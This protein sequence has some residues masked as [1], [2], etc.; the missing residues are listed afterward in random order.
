MSENIAIVCA[1]LSVIFVMAL[2]RESQRKIKPAT[3]QSRALATLAML[4]PLLLLNSCHYQ[5]P[6]VQPNNH[7]FQ[8]EGPNTAPPSR[9]SFDRT[10]RYYA[11][12]GLRKYK[13]PLTNRALVMIVEEG[14]HRVSSVAIFSA[15]RLLT[16]RKCKRAIPGIQKMMERTVLFEVEMQYS[17]CR[18]HPKRFPQHMLLD[19]LRSGYFL[20]MDSINVAKSL[21]RLGDPSQFAIIQNAILHGSVNERADAT[22][23][24]WYFWPHQGKKLENGITI[25]LFPLM[26]AA[27]MD[28]SNTVFVFA[29]EQ[30]RHAPKNPLLKCDLESVYG[31]TKDDYHRYACLEVLVYRY[32]RK[33]NDF[34]RQM[35]SYWSRRKRTYME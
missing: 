11:K 20:P 16:A 6:P 22:S 1:A 24:L 27:L 5:L 35:G 32:H 7:R 21:I 30:Y 12:E 31:S 2:Q 26:H 29:I 23:A 15:M 33:E 14:R 25:D 3:F 19:S 17:L 13:L 34:P 10:Q 28:S 18:I 8:Q 9:L 4:I